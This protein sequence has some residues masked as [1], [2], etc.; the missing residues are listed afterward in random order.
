MESGLVGSAFLAEA[1]PQAKRTVLASLDLPEPTFQASQH[2]PEI[3]HFVRTHR[4]Q[5]RTLLVLDFYAGDAA[6][7]RRARARGY[8]TQTFDI[9]HSPKQ[10]AFT[11]EGYFFGLGLCCSLEM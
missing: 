8:E 3:V 1:T 5:H 2:I 6:F 11:R 9:L 7:S 4:E 10:N